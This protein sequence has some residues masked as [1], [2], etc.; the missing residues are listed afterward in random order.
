MQYRYTARCLGPSLRPSAMKR[1]NLYV[2][3]SHRGDTPFQIGTV[4]H[5]QD[6]HRNAGPPDVQLQGSIVYTHVTL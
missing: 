5:D 1:Y 3:A 6:E 2:A 4:L